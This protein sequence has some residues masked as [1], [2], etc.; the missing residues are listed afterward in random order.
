MEAGLDRTAAYLVDGVRLFVDLFEFLLN[1]SFVQFFVVAA[2]DQVSSQLLVEL[3]QL[4]HLL[5]VDA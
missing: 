3:L 5:L 4:V 1:Q 2:I